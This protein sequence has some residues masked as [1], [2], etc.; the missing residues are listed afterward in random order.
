[1]DVSLPIL[2]V[3]LASHVDWNDEEQC[4]LGVARALGKTFAMLPRSKTIPPENIMDVDEL[5]NSNPNSTEGSSSSS[6]S[7]R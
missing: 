3:E 2:M 5:M 7:N 4:F 6:S 1:M